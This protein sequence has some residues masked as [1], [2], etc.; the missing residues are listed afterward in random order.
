MVHAR[1]KPIRTR[2]RF[3]PIA[4][5][6][7]VAGAAVL[8]ALSLSRMEGHV[9]SAGKQNM[10]AVTEQMEQSYDLQLGRIYERLGWIESNLFLGGARSV[11]LDAQREHLL[12][13]TE[14]T[15]PRAPSTSCSLSAR[16]ARS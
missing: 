8:A 16:T 9:V 13:A 10:L 2:K 14:R 4:L 7:L 1:V 12:N 5:A 15:P 11:D 3:L 6:V